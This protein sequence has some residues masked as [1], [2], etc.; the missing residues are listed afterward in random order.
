MVIRPA[1]TTDR[2]IHTLLA[3]AALALLYSIPTLGYFHRIWPVRND[4]LAGNSDDP[5]FN[6]YVLKWGV[7]QLRLGLPDLWNA[8]FF[9]PVRGALAFSDHLVGPA[10]QLLVL[11][12][13]GLARNAVAGYNLLLLGS[14]VLAGATTCW[15]LRRSG[16]S[17]TAAVLGGF[18]YAFAPMRWAHLEHLQILLAQWI[19]ITLWCWDRLLAEPTWKRAALFLPFYLLHLTG[20][21]YLAYMIHVPMLALLLSRGAAG[22][23]QLVSRRSLQVLLAVALPALAT[24]Y[25]LFAPY[26]EVSRRY[27]LARAPEEAAHYAASLPSYLAPSERNLYAGWW[28]R[29]ADRWRL[30][31]SWD[32]SRL[33]AGFLPTALFVY[34]ALL[35]LRRY[36]AP[37]VR[38]LAAWQRLALGSL[39]ALAA[40]AFLWGDLR[41][42]RHESAPGAWTWPALGCGLGIGFWLLARRLWGGNWSLRCAEMD[43]W[44]RG[45]AA[46]GVLCFLLSFPIVFVPLMH[47]VPGLGGMRAPGRF[48]VLTSFVVVYF[49]AKGLDELLARISPTAPE[50]VPRAAHGRRL[51]AAAALALVLAWELAPAR[52]GARRMR[53][54]AEFAAAY[55]YLHCADQVGAVLELPRL[56]FHSE[57]IY[58]YFSTLHWKP[59]A[60]GY[61]GYQPD[62]DVELREKI[63]LL[64]DGQG[65]ALLEQ[66][67]ITHLVVHAGGPTGRQIRERLPSWEQEFLGRKVARVFT[68]QGDR[69]YQLLDQPAVR[70]RLR[71]ARG[72]PSRPAALRQAFQ[73]PATVPTYPPS[74]VVFCQAG[75]RYCG[76]TAG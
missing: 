34:G 72:A 48:Y 75:P 47:V 31:L 19:P 27:H 45:V 16:R 8:N 15:V 42:L 54:E 35:F 76:S 18:M 2:P 17:W 24:A 64:P 52:I 50:A 74:L 60:N 7:H 69:I 3:G 28:H 26:V 40:C 33:F 39:A 20:G 55:R 10:L 53:D 58:M 4:H 61:S 44:E 43:P 21:T 73:A 5:V 1:P 11:L 6:L 30:D 46:G 63:P 62:S 51:A 36:R 37:P 67:G 68:D 32:E 12:G 65:F 22:W 23:R 49:A 14:F 13:T 38:R 25:L 9:Y 56:P 71:L 59:L 57:S 41:T 66:R 70:P 29:L